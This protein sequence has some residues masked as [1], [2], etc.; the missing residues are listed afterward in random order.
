MEIGDI[1]IMMRIRLLTIVKIVIYQLLFMEIRNRIVIVFLICLWGISVSGQHIDG[2]DLKI[3][4][5]SIIDKN[6]KKCLFGLIPY[7]LQKYPVDRRRDVICVDFANDGNS[8]RVYPRTKF[9]GFTDWYLYQSNYEV[10][11][12]IKIKK[13]NVIFIGNS[14][15]PYVKMRKRSIKMHIENYPPSNGINQPYWEYSVEN[16]GARCI[17]TDK[18]EPQIKGIFY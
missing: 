11:G 15:L 17:Q 18:N 13:I 4:K 5:I 2:Y 16:N 9:E 14:S 8:F 3:K 7:I 1:S 10:V 6:V 12:Y